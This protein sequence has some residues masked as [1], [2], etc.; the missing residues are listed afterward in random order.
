MNEIGMSK[1]PDVYTV[2]EHPEITRKYLDLRYAAKTKSEYLD[3]YLPEEGEGPFPVCLLYT[4]RFSRLRLTSLT[5][6]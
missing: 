4:S 2:V 1:H 5:F 6:P 3:I